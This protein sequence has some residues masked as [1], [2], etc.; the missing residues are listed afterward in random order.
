MQRDSMPSPSAGTYRSGERGL[1]LLAYVMRETH[2]CAAC[3][4]GG[5]LLHAAHDISA[6]RHHTCGA[7]RAAYRPLYTCSVGPSLEPWA[8]AGA[9]T[10]TGGNMSVIS[11]QACTG[12]GGARRVRS[13]TVAVG[14]HGGEVELLEQIRRGGYHRAAETHVVRLA[15]VLRESAARSPEP[16]RPANCGVT[17]T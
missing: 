4:A 16:T 5:Y 2:T 3:R 1:H 11:A 6:G 9:F 13:A 14:V 12:H 17:R 15:E 10:P 7:R 8:G